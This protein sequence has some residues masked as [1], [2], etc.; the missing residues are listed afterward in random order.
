MSEFLAAATEAVG[1]PEPLVQRSADARAAADGVPVEDI[2]AAWAGGTAPSPPAAGPPAEPTAE[3]TPAVPE[4]PPAP[5]PAPEETSEP[6]PEPA[7]TTA[8][9]VRTTR[10]VP[11]TVGVDQARE[12]ESVITVP[13]AG[14]KERTATRVPSWLTAVFVIL[15]LIGLLYLLQFSDGP[16]CGTSGLLAVDGASGEVVN[17][18]GSPFEGRGAP[19]GSTNFLALGQSLYADPQVACNGCHGDNG[20]GGVG[21]TFAG[22]AV[23]ATFPTC[24]DHVQWV[25]LGSSGWQAQVGTEY[26]AAGILSLGGM[27]GFGDDLSDEDLRSVI[28]F[29]RVRFGGA[30]LDETLVDCGLVIPEAPD[31]GEGAPPGENGD[32]TADGSEEAGAEA[33]G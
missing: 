14:L 27:P 2:L 3:E 11:E 20:E 23:L 7:P 22:G 5:E 25:Q 9:P 33:S 31:E 12:W 21:P 17:C 18:D 28:A 16:D 15:P 26:G 29:E 8:S 10:P 30:D 6:T 1:V 19:G 13:T 32:G 4:E 24:A